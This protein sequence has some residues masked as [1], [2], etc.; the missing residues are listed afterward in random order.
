MTRTHKTLVTLGS[1]ALIVSAGAACAQDAA[2]KPLGKGSFVI[3]A[4]VTSVAPSEKGEILTAAGADSGLHVDVNNDVAPTLGFTYFFTDHIA[5][6]AILGTSQHTIKAV[7]PGTDVQVHKTWVLPPVVTLQYHFNPKGKINPYI[8]AGVNYM[9]W[10][11]G[12]DYNGFTVKLKSGAGTALQ[13]GADIA[14]KGPW[15]LNIDVKKVFY[16]T[17]ATINSGALKSRV[18]LDPAVVS[19]GLGYRF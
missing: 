14:L 2:Y 5:A 17:D 11:S 4:R 16:K 3:D 15:A 19:L 9:D 6:E 1:F 8:G 7:G 10:Y 13:A 18:K 12:K